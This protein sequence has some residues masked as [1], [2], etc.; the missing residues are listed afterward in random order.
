MF[1]RAVEV[2]RRQEFSIRHRL[3]MIGVAA[4]ADE[5][6]DV[7]VPRSDIVVGDRPVHAIAELF[8]RHEL[9]LTPALAG[10]AP[11]YRLAPNL[12]AADPVERLLLDV[13]MVAILDEE[14]HG[15]LAVA[16]RLADQRIFLEDLAR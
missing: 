13:R 11:D 15:V 1:L 5:F 3:Q 7:R 8:G 4:N 10:A 14:V 16:R 9:V 2:E 12:K 6:L